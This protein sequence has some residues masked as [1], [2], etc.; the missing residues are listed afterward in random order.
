M[1]RTPVQIVTLANL[2]RRRN[3]LLSRLSLLHLL[4]HQRDIVGGGDEPPI[5][6]HQYSWEYD[7]ANGVTV[8]RHPHNNRRN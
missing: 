5:T 1:L 2:L 4:V 3:V 8:A 6:V 7:M